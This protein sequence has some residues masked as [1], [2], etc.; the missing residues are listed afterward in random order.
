[1]TSPEVARDLY[2]TLIA[3]G[4]ASWC[5]ADGHGNVPGTF[6]EHL[7][8]VPSGSERSQSGANPWCRCGRTAALAAWE[9]E[10]MWP[11]SPVLSLVS[12]GRG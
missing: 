5:P 2:H 8:T 7:G 1:M 11:R 10:R 6:P 3:A 9:S 4:H 12:E